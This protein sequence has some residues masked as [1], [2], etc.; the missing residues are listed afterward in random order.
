MIFFSCGPFLGK[1]GDLKI[2]KIFL[3]EWTF[4]CLRGGGYVRL[5]GPTPHRLLVA[6]TF[7]RAAP[8]VFWG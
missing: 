3:D 2:L 5:K 6:V 1:G 7:V 4:C 8:P